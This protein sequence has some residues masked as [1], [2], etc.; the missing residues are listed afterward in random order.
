MACRGLQPGVPQN[1]NPKPT[2]NV[3][4]ITSFLR[5]AADYE[6]QDT[7]IPKRVN[8]SYFKINESAEGFLP[9]VLFMDEVQCCISWHA[10]LN[11]VQNNVTY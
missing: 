3:A 7:D 1:Q 10:K 9:H 11:N 2:A 8:N 6:I 5:T 4:D